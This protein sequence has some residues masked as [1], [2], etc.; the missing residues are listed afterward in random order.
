MGYILMKEVEGSGYIELRRSPVGRRLPH[1]QTGRF[2]RMMQKLI[3]KVIL[4]K[5]QNWYVVKG[6][7]KDEN[8]LSVADACQ[9]FL[10][11]QQSDVTADLYT[12][13]TGLTITRRQVATQN[14]Q[15]G[16]CH[17]DVLSF[18]PENYLA[19]VNSDK[20]G[21][22]K[23]IVYFCG[24]DSYYQNCFSDI[25]TAAKS[26][27]ATVHAF[28]YPGVDEGVARVFEFNDMVN[29]GIAVVN[30][31][32]K[33]GIHPDDVILQGDSFGSSVAHAV[34]MQF[35]QQSDCELRIVANNTFG[36]FKKAI[37]DMILSTVWIPNLSQATIKNI[38]QR[39]GWHVTLGKHYKLSNPYQCFVQHKDDQTLQSSKLSYKVQKYQ[40]EAK[41]AITTSKKRG[42]IVDTCPDDYKDQRDE[43]DSLSMVQVSR[44]AEA[45]LAIKYG[46]NKVGLV[47]SHLASLCDCET[48][49]GKEA[50]TGLVNKYLSYSN[51]YIDENRQMSLSEASL[52]RF[53]STHVSDSAGIEAKSVNRHKKSI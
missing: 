50:Y 9:Y 2:Y 3:T 41:T 30:S 35:K 18:D 43:L 15:G 20:P 53:L 8:G 36:S 13:F 31:L 34:K 22:G 28:N 1:T 46:R 21:A 16:H 38:L 26:T 19:Q 7:N 24:A 42:P 32:L 6:F 37:M 12:Y 25:A 5:L 14:C 52:P 11:K 47:D 45:R 10:E 33:R 17:F 51:D 4:P 29:S 39:A 48:I 27:G 23:H 44:D 49:D 40:H